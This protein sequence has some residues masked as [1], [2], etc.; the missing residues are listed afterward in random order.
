MVDVI[1]EY[2]EV[3]GGEIPIPS[4]LQMASIPIGFAIF[5]RHDIASNTFVGCFSGEAVESKDLVDPAYS[6]NLDERFFIDA[7]HKG[8][9]V[10]FINH[11]KENAKLLGV[12]D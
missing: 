8:N 9:Y 10:R 11:S 2:E 1:A 5:A 6:F 12:Y 4:F 3:L 7:K